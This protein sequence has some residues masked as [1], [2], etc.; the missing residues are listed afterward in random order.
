FEALREI[1]DGQARDIGALRDD[2]LIARRSGHRLLRG[3]RLY[4][5]RGESRDGEIR[6]FVWVHLAERAELQGRQSEGGRLLLVA[7]LHISAL[8]LHHLC[9]G[10]AEAPRAE[11]ARVPAQLLRLFR[12]ELAASLCR[13]H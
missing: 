11:V 7:S 8:Q 3:L 13:V 2:V 9:A 1:I 5:V 4:A 10:K 12:T 6:R